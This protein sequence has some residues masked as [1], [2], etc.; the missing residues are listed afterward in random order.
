[1]DH[2]KF[3]TTTRRPPTDLLTTFPCGRGKIAMT[4]APRSLFGKVASR[5]GGPATHPTRLASRTGRTK[6]WCGRECARLVTHHDQTATRFS[7][8]RSEA[9]QSSMTRRCSHPMARTRSSPRNIRE[10]ST[11][12]YRIGL[13]SVHFRVFRGLISVGFFQWLGWKRVQ[14]R[15]GQRP[16]LRGI[17]APESMPRARTIAG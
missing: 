15:P 7:T 9:R 10:P 5:S 14:V 1:L 11:K 4:P 12:E 17:H 2:D 6:T 8:G 16:A 3:G 13:P